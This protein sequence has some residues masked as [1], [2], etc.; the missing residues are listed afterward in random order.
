MKR[1]ARFNAIFPDSHW[2]KY[3]YF[4]VSTAL[5][6]PL[7]AQSD[8]IQSNIA[9]PET[10][11]REYRFNRTG[12]TT[13]RA[14]SLPV[15]AV[16]SA[17]ERLFWENGLDLRQNAP[18]TLATL[19]ARGAGPNRTAVLWN[20]LSLQS[21]M[22]G[23]IDI[24]LIPLWSG[25]QLEVLQ[26]GNSAAQ[27]NGAMG[28]AVLFET[29]L[30][31]RRKGWAGSAGLQ[32]GSY[33][34]KSAQGSADVVS[35]AYAGRFRA[36]WQS[37]ENNFPF[38]KT[39]LNGQPFST[40]QENN[41]GEKTDVQQFNQWNINR[42]N[43]LKTAAWFQHAFR[44]IPPT[45]TEAA[46]DTWQRDQSGRVVA[47]WEHT[48]SQRAK[49]STRM[50][51]QDEFIGFHFA[52]ATEES[53]AQTA[54]LGTEYR[55]KNGRFEWRF[56]GSA[57]HT[58]AISDGYKR[59]ENWYRQTRAAGFALAEYRFGRQGKVSALA[60]Q[61]WAEGQATP[62]TWTAGWEI[63]L[64]Q[65]GA[66]RGHLSRN[67]NLP[68]FN[69]R[70]WKTLNSDTLRPEKGY[71]AD[72][73]WLWQKSA[74]GI[75]A[76]VFQLI[77]DDWILWQPGSDGIFRPGNLRKVNSRGLELSGSFSGRLGAI[78]W[79]LKGRAQVSE[80]QNVAVYGGSEDVL[81]KQLPYTPR[82][83]AGGGLWFNYHNLAGAYLQ[84]WTG[85]R[86]VTTDNVTALPA[87]Q[88]GTLL[89]H[90]ELG[91][92]RFWRWSSSMAIDVTLANIWNT[93]YESL[94]GRPMPGQNWKAGIVMGW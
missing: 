69:D 44:Q 75:E 37:A 91:R 66:L 13:W 16:I 80:T 90:Y 3:G 36:H 21:P 34:W 30:P 81:H 85:Q 72:F 94:A 55:Q 60:R 27:S 35:G 19:S 62:F 77:L 43:V 82:I 78:H 49:W 17:S 38:Q 89:L 84:Q 12:Y 73:G 67:Y 63:P 10:T 15:S 93:S 92:H 50:A 76:T 6:L 41:F 5:W 26:G 45:A 31:K 56:G 8:S 33:G 57:Q 14:D 59:G 42:K 32:G 74:F 25:D 20:G 18:G 88:T 87:Y 53:R 24:S 65:L 2:F 61:E 70:F 40:R 52:G 7:S 46:S 11:V 23:V 9:L 1:F 39:A 68:T 79:K 86:F 54:L 71:S 47:T 58:R 51:W 48:P 4:F 29:P 64:R 83:S 22:N 28:G